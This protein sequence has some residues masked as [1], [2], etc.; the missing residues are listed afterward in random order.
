MLTQYVDHT[1]ATGNQRL[2][3]MYGT[4]AGQGA[5]GQLIKAASGSGSSRTS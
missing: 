4:N 3:L 2:T 1:L 5:A